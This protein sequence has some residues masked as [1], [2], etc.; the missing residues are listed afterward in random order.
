MK[1]ELGT[2]N[3]KSERQP[4]PTNDNQHWARQPTADNQ[5]QTITDSNRR[6]LTAITLQQ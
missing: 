1:A 3:G 2:N 5:E 4:T 6:Q